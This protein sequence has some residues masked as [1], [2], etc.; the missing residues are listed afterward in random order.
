MKQDC[1]TLLCAILLSSVFSTV[2]RA[3]TEPAEPRSPEEAARDYFGQRLEFLDGS[4]V[5][6]EVE[7][8]SAWD[9]TPARFA[10]VR[11]FTRRLGNG[12]PGRGQHK[13]LVLHQS[14]EIISQI[15][16]SAR[17]AAVHADGE[18]RINAL[19]AIRLQTP[20]DALSLSDVTYDDLLQASDAAGLAM[21]ALTLVMEVYKRDGRD[22][23]TTEAVRRALEPLNLPG[24]RCC[25]GSPLI[26]VCGGLPELI[27]EIDLAEPA[28]NDITVPKLQMSKVWEVV[29]R[30]SVIDRDGAKTRV[31]ALVVGDC[32]DRDRVRS[33][34]VRRVPLPPKEVAPRV[35][36][37]AA[38]PE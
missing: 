16:F 5:L 38:E 36:S 8:V 30:G 37:D 15:W 9:D 2:A 35:V 4:V 20:R 11:V 27:D 29:V 24:E 17:P 7:A 19:P 10:V 6:D 3:A 34:V 21:E 32:C 18:L 12:A 31:E 23:L 28:F 25:F 1:I 13:L 26:E 33:I 22:A 14:G